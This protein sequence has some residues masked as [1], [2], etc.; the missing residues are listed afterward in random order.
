MA[1]R[2]SSLSV[3]QGVH[4]FRNSC[5]SSR[6]VVGVAIQDWVAPEPVAGGSAADRRRART[7]VRPS[8]TRSSVSFGWLRPEPLQ[9]RAGLTVRH[10]AGSRRPHTVKDAGIGIIVEERRLHHDIAGPWVTVAAVVCR[11]VHAPLRVTSLCPILLLT[12][13]DGIVQT[14]FGLPF[15]PVRR[16]ESDAAD[17]ESKRLAWAPRRQSRSSRREI[18][19][20]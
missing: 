10:L 17:A 20:V 15:G 4:P 2:R 9:R 19:P 1:G 7:P 3:Y 18:H 11:E 8:G 5:P 13:V 6:I 12:I 14:P 16:T